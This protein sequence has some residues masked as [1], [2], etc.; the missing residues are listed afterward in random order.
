MLN[1]LPITMNRNIQNNRTCSNNINFKAEIP[2]STQ[3]HAKMQE[4]TNAL[5]H[6]AQQKTLAELCDTVLTTG[7]F[8]KKRKIKVVADLRALFKSIT[9]QV[10]ELP[11]DITNLKQNLMSALDKK[12]ETIEQQKATI[13]KKDKTIRDLRQEVSNIQTQL[14]QKESE[15][16]AKEE[17]L[18]GER[19][20]IVND[21]DFGELR[22]TEKGAKQYIKLTSELNTAAANAEQKKKSINEAEQYINAHKYHGSAG[23]T[24]I[25]TVNA[26]LKDMQ[27]FRTELATY[28]GQAN[29]ARAKIQL[30]Q[31]SGELPES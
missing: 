1:T 12:T 19:P 18:S 9:D 31:G 17:L 28:E 16:K 6:S 8:Y 15:L 13:E 30:L 24:D 26:T 21:K 22:L 14:T 20:Y 25:N 27:R 10:S 5:D 2:N 4:I 7:I 23:Y 3:L 11:K 29:A